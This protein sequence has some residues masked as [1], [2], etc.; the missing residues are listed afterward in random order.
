[1]LETSTKHLMATKHGKYQH[2]NFI[3]TVVQPS[4]HRSITGNIRTMAGGGL[5][6]AHR[7]KWRGTTKRFWKRRLV[8]TV[9][10]AQRVCSSQV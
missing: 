7:P 10:V 6:S 3:L 8:Q 4:N 9:H 1:M 2:Q 5:C